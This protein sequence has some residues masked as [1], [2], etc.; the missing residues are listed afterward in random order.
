MK[1]LRPEEVTTFPEFKEYTPDELKQAYALA[2]AAFTV[3]DLL[4]F[5]EIV[6]EIPARQVMA[7][8]EK[9]QKEADGENA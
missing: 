8:I 4:R 6:E 2:Q 5:T 1:I 3:E 7:E 9:D